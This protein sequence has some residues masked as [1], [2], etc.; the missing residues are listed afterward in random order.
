MFW[1][2]SADYLLNF[3]FL[4]QVECPDNPCDGE[5]SSGSPRVH[6]SHKSGLSLTRDK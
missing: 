2:T 4:G 3:Y 5:R 1:S 6:S